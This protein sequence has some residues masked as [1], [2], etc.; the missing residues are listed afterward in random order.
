MFSRE[1]QPA[2]PRAHMASL[3]RPFRAILSA[4]QELASA[5]VE[6]SMLYFLGLASACA[7]AHNVSRS[8]SCLR[9]KRDESSAPTAYRFFF[10]P[11]GG[12]HKT[13]FGKT[14]LK[15]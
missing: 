9:C 12:V 1:A 4:L 7:S 8:L 15:L 10:P 14:Y 13:A 11:L 6:G 2:A 5:V 3:N